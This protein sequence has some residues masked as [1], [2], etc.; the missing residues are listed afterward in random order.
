MHFTPNAVFTS[1]VLASTSSAFTPTNHL[2]RRDAVFSRSPSRHVNT[3]LMYEPDGNAKRD[4]GSMLS[5]LANT[6][7]W[8]SDTL[9]QH[10]SARPNPHSRKEISYVCENTDDPIMTVANIFRQVKEARELGESYAETEAEAADENGPEYVP[11]TL[12]QTQVMVIPWCDNFQSFQNFETTYQAINTARRAARDYVTDLSCEKFERMTN[13][14]G[15]EGD[16]SVSVSLAS[17][18]P[19]YGLE[20]KEECLSQ[21]DGQDMEVDLKLEE[22]QKKRLLARQSP[23]PTLAL[24]IKAM[25]PTN[26]EVGPTS[27]IEGSSNDADQLPAMNGLNQLEAMYCKSSVT[28]EIEDYD[29]IG[30]VFGIEDVPVDNSII[31]ANG[32]KKWLVQNDPLFDPNS[33]SFVTSDA[34][35]VDAAYE[36]VFTAIATYEKVNLSSQSIYIMM[37]HFLTQSATSLEKFSWEVF[38]I[39]QKLE[40]KK[41]YTVSIFHPENVVPERRSSVPTVVFQS[42]EDMLR[43]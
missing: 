29:S 13:G 17:L 42:Y 38:N 8:I 15:I 34:D 4:S 12:R 6:E 22:Y 3:M 20:S 26:F 39:L 24:E 37:P 5:V 33:S 31:H 28:C 9:G 27:P 30:S 23:Y 36:D 1:L 43:P 14:N 32:A 7:R 11:D 2:P 10:K 18:H 16:W 19:D 35:E 21:N 41:L 40:L 25:P